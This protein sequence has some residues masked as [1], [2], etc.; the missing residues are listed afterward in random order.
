[1]FP[2]TSYLQTVVVAELEKVTETVDDIL[3][4]SYTRPGLMEWARPLLQHHRR[5]DETVQSNIRK[6]P[7]L[8]L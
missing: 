2:H 5:D 3:I 1:M 7:V 4:E 8:R 6:I